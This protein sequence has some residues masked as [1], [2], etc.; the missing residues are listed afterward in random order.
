VV[1]GG[2]DVTVVG[3][4]LTVGIARKAA[5]AGPSMEVIDLRTLVPWDSEL[6][7]E[8]VSRTGRLVTVEEGPYSGGW[9]AEVVAHVAAQLHGQLK[10]PSLRITSPDVPIPFAG[11]LEERY[12]PTVQLVADQVAQLVTTDAAVAPWWQTEVLA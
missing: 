3:S 6:V 1:E 9:G 12:L 2:S 8:S 5:D 4:G 10:A 11:A 7:L